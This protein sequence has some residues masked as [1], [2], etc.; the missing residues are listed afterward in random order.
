MDE[1]NEVLDALRTANIPVDILATMGAGLSA[2][3]RTVYRFILGAF[4][5]L[6]GPPDLEQLWAEARR[7]GAEPEAVLEVLA[8]RALIVRDR[9]T[10]AITV[11]Y[12]FSTMPTAHR[13]EVVGARPVYAMCAIDALG[14]PFMLNRDAVIISHDPLSGEPIRVSVRAG[15]AHWEPSTA[16]VFVC[17]P[18][19]CTG[20]ECCAAINFFGSAESSDAY[21]RAYPDVEGIVLGHAAAA[22]AGKQLFGHLLVA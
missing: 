21:R 2:S 9:A 17:T 5:T 15:Q 11:A 7:L 22:A 10:G 14:I 13:V 18:R 20:P 6:G 8:Q 16:V 3:E 1:V 4:P 12:P 19:G